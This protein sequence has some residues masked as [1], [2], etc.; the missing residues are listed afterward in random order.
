MAKKIFDI[1]FRWR[2]NNSD[3]LCNDG[4]LE[5]VPSPDENFGDNQL[6]PTSPGFSYD[7]KLPAS[8][9]SLTSFALKRTTLPGWNINPDQYP[10]K[11]LVASE[12]S[13]E[14]W[15]K[16][17]AQLLGRFQ[18]EAASQNLFTAPF[19]AK[20]AWKLTT[21]QY[22]SITDPFLLTPN[23]QIP[24][25][26]TD[27][28]ILAD[29]VK[30]KVAGA[31]CSLTLKMTAPEWLRD[32]VGIIEALEIF[33]SNPLIKYDSLTS[34]LPSKNVT[35]DNYCEAIDPVSGNVKRTRVCTESLPIGWKAAKLETL[36]ETSYIRYASI[37]LA[38]VDLL[39]DRSSLDAWV[40]PAGEEFNSSLSSSSD[41][42][43]FTDPVIIFG[44]NETVN[45]KTR[46]IKL[47]S[48][49]E[50][51]RVSQIFLRGHFSPQ[52]ITFTA[53]GSRDM[54]HWWKIATTRGNILQLPRSSFRFFS[55]EISG[56]L[57]EGETLEGFTIVRQ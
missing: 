24:V 31:V 42:S 23:S 39:R 13:M 33:V 36:K 34:L 35:T 16:L 27:G 45:L 21:G 9:Q 2:T 20:A 5:S 19:Y 17:T 10:M 30:F 54:L 1:P 8:L 38:D 28:N 49:G 11:T 43:K 7:D 3:F 57:A 18:S 47:S 56:L 32:W 4:E 52:S 55:L 48:P 14:Y 41:K 37:P 15:N 51:K 6:F 50:L 53:Y 26:T 29:E 46:P 44:R 22:I 40:T 25:V 12:P